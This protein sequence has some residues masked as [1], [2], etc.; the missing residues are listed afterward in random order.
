MRVHRIID[1]GK[2]SLIFYQILS[3]NSLRKCMEISLENL[4]VDIGAKKVKKEST[5]TWSNF[6]FQWTKLLHQN[7]LKHIHYIA[8]FAR[9]FKG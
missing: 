5:S 1:Q 6:D 3:T 2:K 7:Y 9:F 4:Y 8:F